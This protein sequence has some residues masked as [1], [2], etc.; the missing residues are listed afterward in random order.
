LELGLIIETNVVSVQNNQ[1]ELEVIGREANT[2]RGYEYYTVIPYGTVFYGLKL[3][4]RL[5]STHNNNIVLQLSG[6]LPTISEEAL[7]LFSP[8]IPAPIMKEPPIFLEQQIQYRLY[9]D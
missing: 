2:L 7:L 3:D 9:L 5:V 1:I 6:I 8:D 4:A